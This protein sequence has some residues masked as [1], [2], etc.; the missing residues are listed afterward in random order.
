MTYLDISKTEDF[1]G[2]GRLGFRRTLLCVNPFGK[3]VYVMRTHV[4]WK[5]LVCISMIIFS[6]AN[7]AEGAENPW[8]DV[9]EYSSLAEA[10]TRIGAGPTTLMISEVRMVDQMKRFW[11]GL[12]L[13]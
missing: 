12:V 3:E 10:I 8:V 6:V 9:S 2:F 13:T 1:L 7:S 11:V 5:L 4:L